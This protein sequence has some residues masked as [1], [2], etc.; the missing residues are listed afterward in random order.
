MYKGE[1]SKSG[2][3][4]LP[5]KRARKIPEKLQVSKEDLDELKASS[6]PESS[7][8]TTESET[9]DVSLDELKEVEA[10]ENTDIKEDTEATNS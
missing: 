5:S 2:T 3:P 1:I 7:N 10:Q 4:I 6:E 8:Q 9:P